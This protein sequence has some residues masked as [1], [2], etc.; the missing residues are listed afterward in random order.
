[1]ETA[2]SW[3]NDLFQAALNF[4]PHRVIIQSVEA[5]IKFKH[6]KVYLLKPGTHMYWPLFSE[7]FSYPINLQPID[8]RPQI[9]YDKEQSAGKVSAALTYKIKDPLKAFTIAHDLDDTLKIY[10]LGVI[11]KGL[12]TVCVNKLQ[13][14]IT[15]VE[16]KIYEDIKEKFEEWGVEL[17]DFFFSDYSKCRVFHIDTNHGGV[18]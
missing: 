8:V 4:I 16:A 11:N 3:L 2:F 17:V 6:G 12:R 18:I 7:V 5:G 13:K 15:Q 1:M 9:F 10:V 14:E